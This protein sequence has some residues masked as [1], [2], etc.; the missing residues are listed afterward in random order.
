[1]NN[2]SMFCSCTDTDCPMHPTNHE[3]GCA[4]CIS[5][6]LN[7]RE[8]PSCFFHLVEDTHGTEGYTLEDFAN[9]VIQGRTSMEQQE[10]VLDSKKIIQ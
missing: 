4:P 10:P 9:A 8:I 5:K 7:L 6:C 1:M 3:K 2:L